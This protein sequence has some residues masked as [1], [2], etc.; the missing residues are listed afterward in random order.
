MR[1]IVLIATFTALLMGSASA[2]SSW[3]EYVYSDKGFAVSFPAE[4][5]V[6][7]MPY[8]LKHCIPPGGIPACT[9]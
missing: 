8:T 1:S 4:P 3:K 5:A 7:T 6:S 9:G 2:Q